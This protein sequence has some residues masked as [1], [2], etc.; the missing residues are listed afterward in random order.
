MAKHNFN[1]G[2]GMGYLDRLQAAEQAK[3][4]RKM[5]IQVDFLLQIGCDAFVMTAADLWDLQPARAVEAVSAYRDYIYKLMDH[6]I[7]DAR[8]DP[9]LAYFWT[10]LDRRLEQIVGKQAFVPRER[11]YD[12]T[13]QR[14]F[15]Q[16]LERF[17][18]RNGGTD[19]AG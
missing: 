18:A 3:Y 5:Q 12:Q 11:R 14:V 6:L 4:D 16:L 1:G 10:D 19:H 15:N 17:K 2:K 8:D 9:E 7:D 13:G